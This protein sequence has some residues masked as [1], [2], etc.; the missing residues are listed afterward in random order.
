MEVASILFCTF[1][2]LIL[3]QGDPKAQHQNPIKQNYYP[4]ASA[5]SSTKETPDSLYANLVCIMLHWLKQ[6]NIPLYAVYL[7]KSVEV[8]CPSP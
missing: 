3:N 7:L 1:M 5:K 6:R 8:V 2:A 4:I